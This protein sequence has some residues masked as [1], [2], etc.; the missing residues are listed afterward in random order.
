VKCDQKSRLVYQKKEDMRE[1]PQQDIV[2]SKLVSG[3]AF[4]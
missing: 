2:Q 4:F 3:Q 1:E